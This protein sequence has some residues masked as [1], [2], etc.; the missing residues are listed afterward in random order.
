MHSLIYLALFML[1]AAPAA[2]QVAASARTDSTRMYLGGQMTLY[3][4]IQQPAG[5]AI[6]APSLPS[7]GEHRPE[8]LSENKWDTLDDSGGQLRLS[9]SFV[10]TVWDTGILQIPPVS[11]PFQAGE[12]VD[13]AFTEAIFLE[14]LLPPV[15]TTLADIKPILAEPANWSDF[16]PYLMAIG[17]LLLVIALVLYLRKRGSGPAIAAPPPALRP[18]ELALQQIEELRRKQLWQQGAV[19]AYHSELTHIIRQY[20]ENRYGILALEQTTAEIL[21]Q[22]RQLGLDE[23]QSGKLKS[24]LETADLVKFAKAEPPAYFHDRAMA[25]VE[26]FVHETKPVVLPAGETAI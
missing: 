10:F 14:V 26:A 19:K 9:K 12:N 1:A 6:Q 25:Y 21:D 5:F 22:W 16:L 11:V 18:E 24:L 23:T 7:T 2:T 8:F 4:E 3:L 20:L 17:F 15:D 13:T